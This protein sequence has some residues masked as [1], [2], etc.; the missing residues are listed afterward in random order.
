MHGRELVL[1]RDV[2]IRKISVDVA[3]ARLREVRER[4]IGDAPRPQESNPLR[5]V[6]H[7][8]VGQA[9][10]GRVAGYPLA[11][12]LFTICGGGFGECDDRLR[13]VEEFVIDFAFS[14]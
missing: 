8:L 10:E 13:S 6:F 11:G 5:D 2:K 1:L 4:D 7:F 12:S 14:P 3:F 9:G